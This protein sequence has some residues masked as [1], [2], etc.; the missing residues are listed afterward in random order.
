[1]NKPCVLIIGPT[2]PPYM[3]PSVATKMIIESELKDEFH[4]VHLDT[5]DRRSLTNIGKVDFGN[6]YLAVAH[7][8]KLIALLMKFSPRI[9][10]LPICQTIRGYFR[11]VSFMTIS[12]I[13][14]ARIIIHLRGGYFRKLYENSNIFA[15][16]IIGFSL[17]SVSRAIVLGES[18]RYVFEDLV[19]S[20]HIVVVSNGIDEEYITEAE[21][22]KAQRNRLITKSPSD[23]MTNSMSGLRVLFL[24]NI[25]LSKGYYDIIKAI[26]F[27]TEK[28]KNVKFIFAGESWES[29]EVTNNVN[30]YIDKQNISR[31]INFYG[32]ALEKDK[33]KL[34]LQSDIMILPT[35]YKY[36]GQPWVIIEAMASGLPVITTDNGCIPEM[37]VDG[38]NGY[39]IEKRNSKQLADRL[40]ILLRNARLRDSMSKQNRA[41]FI[42]LYTKDVYIKGL[43]GVFESVLSQ[44]PFI[45]N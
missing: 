16:V 6:I 38:Q 10:Y 2:P 15:K 31:Y 41:R 39:I 28:I 37:I 14:G 11:D 30:D 35:Y 5:A 19:P 42:K 33:R 34:L 25:L 8:L 27:I 26:P 1:M 24:S 36:E 23:S 44:Y 4:L 17:K 7:F 9:V 22:T 32:R 3:G 21:Y 45:K 12:R 43:R 29:E 13:F 18:L 40:L 20:K